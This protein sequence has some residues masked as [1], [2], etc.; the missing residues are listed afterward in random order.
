MALSRGAWEALLRADGGEGE[1]LSEEAWLRYAMWEEHRR[2]Q[3]L[4]SVNDRLRRTIKAH[5][6]RI[7]ELEG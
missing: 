7:R 6:A 1:E 5:E 2:A 3:R 4:S